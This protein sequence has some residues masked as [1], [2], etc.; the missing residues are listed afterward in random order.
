MTIPTSHVLSL[1]T[2]LGLFPTAAPSPAGLPGHWVRPEPLPLLP[3]PSKGQV[4]N[5]TWVQ[6]LLAVLWG[7]VS[8]VFTLR[9]M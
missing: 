6:G 2:G 8:R 3:P 7:I 1:I 9:Q 5:R 4:V